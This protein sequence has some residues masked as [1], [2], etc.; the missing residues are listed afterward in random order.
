[1][2]VHIQQMLMNI[3]VLYVPNQPTY[4]SSSK[5]TELYEQ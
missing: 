5:Y 2:E 4:A 3:F 1:M